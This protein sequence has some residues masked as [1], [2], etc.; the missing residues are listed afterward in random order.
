MANSQP[1]LAEMR[2][3]ADEGRQ[4][5]LDGS[6]SQEASIRAGPVSRGEPPDR[7]PGLVSR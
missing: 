1:R 3:G 2:L 5:M 6:S 4:N 7:H